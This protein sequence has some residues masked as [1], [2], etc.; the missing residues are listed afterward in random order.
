MSGTN[1]DKTGWFDY[2]ITDNQRKLN[3]ALYNKSVGSVSGNGKVLI[4][5]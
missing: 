3:R 4:L 2:N 1:K 5:N